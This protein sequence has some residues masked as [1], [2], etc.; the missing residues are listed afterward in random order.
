MRRRGAL[1][2]VIL[3]AVFLFNACAHR[4]DSFYFGAFSDGEQYFNKGEYEKA[5]EK[6]QA[7]IH[8]NPEGNLSIISRYYI[9]KS[10]LALGETDKAKE[11]F[12]LIVRDYPEQVWANFAKTQLEEI[13]A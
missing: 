12:E 8:E 10:Y 7:Y 4:G 13:N 11:A 2:G 1:L 9:G 6:Y 3:A 5:V